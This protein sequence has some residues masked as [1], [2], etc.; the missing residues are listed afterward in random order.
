MD[1]SD[2]HQPHESQILRLSIDKAMWQLGWRP[3]WN[4]R[5]SLQ[6]T[7]G[8]YQAYFQRN[9]DIVELSKRQIEL[10]ENADSLNGVAV[11]PTLNPIE[12]PTIFASTNS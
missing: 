2:P 3:R 4:L 12:T 11:A 5:R 9:E 8:W 6:E 10:Y 7:V 1:V